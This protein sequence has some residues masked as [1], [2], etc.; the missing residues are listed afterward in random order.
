MIKIKN[1]TK[2]YETI[3]YNVIALSNLNFQF[4]KGEVIV[5]L[6]RSGSGKSTFLN[7]LGGFDNTYSGSY[8]FAKNEFKTMAQSE[9]DALRSKKIGFIFQHQVLFNNLTVIENVEISLDVLGVTNS[10]KKRLNAMKALTLVGLRRH[11]YKKPWQLSGGEKQRLAVARAI[12]KDPEVII[13]DEPTAALD[14]LTSKEVL[15]LLASVCKNKLLIIATHNKSIVK[16]YGTRI[17]ELKSGYVVRDELVKADK[18]NIEVDE[19]DKLLDEDIYRDEEIIESESDYEILSDK[20]EKSQI[21]KDL[22][23]DISQ[24]KERSE[25]IFHIDEKEKHATIQRRKEEVTTEEK[26]DS[27]SDGTED[28][29]NVKDFAGKAFLYHL[30]TY[31]FLASFLVIF[32][33]IFILGF[34]IASN[35]FMKKDNTDEI[36]S[37]IYK[38]NYVL[39]LASYDEI[40]LYLADKNDIAQLKQEFIE[41]NNID[42]YS[43]KN[44]DLILND[45]SFNFRYIN[46]IYHEISKYLDKEKINYALYYDPQNI[47]LGNKNENIIFPSLQTRYWVEKSNNHL[48]MN[49][50]SGQ[51]TNEGITP[52]FVEGYTDII[53]PFLISNSKL[54][55]KADEVLISVETLINSNVLKIK[56]KANI[57]EVY[58]QFEKLKDKYIEIAVPK[59]VIKED[60]IDNTQYETLRFK[61]VGI[62]NAGINIQANYHNLNDT[63]M[64]FAAA[65]RDSISIQIDNQTDNESHLIPLY[66]EIDQQ[67]YGDK[68]L[69]EK[70]LEIQATYLA[71]EYDVIEE[72]LATY[73][74]PLVNAFAEISKGETSLNTAVDSNLYPGLT[75]KDLSSQQMSSNNPNSLVY[76]RTIN[77]LF[78]NQYWNQVNNYYY[79]RSNPDE[80]VPYTSFKLNNSLV[81]SDYQKLDTVIK[82]LINNFS[83]SLDFSLDNVI[84]TLVI[85]VGRAYLN[86]NVIV[87]MITSIVSSILVVIIMYIFEWILAKLLLNIYQLFLVNRRSEFGS[88]RILGAK[89]DHIKQILKSEGKYL[90]NLS[91]LVV[92]VILIII[93]LITI[94]NQ[95]SLDIYLYQ[96]FNYMFF[97]IKI[98]DFFDISLF[99]VIS[100][101]ILMQAIFK[102]QLIDENINQNLKDLKMLNAITEWDGE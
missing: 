77:T 6:G 55:T 91:Y 79:Y 22:G 100:I 29:A 41:V 88:L 58:R 54:P 36:N 13:C 60:E 5:I 47:L 14:S 70:I 56:N 40:G 34:N 99:S 89:F 17:I 19:F 44:Y 65:A 11:A 51:S 30:K 53:K 3:N 76:E 31:L 73:Y 64:F 32:I 33:I 61:I 25:Q 46:D 59:M 63:K 86:P 96:P 71:N 78:V 23:L 2:V 9:I 57:N 101:F 97:N 81:N 42:T 28:M 18:S 15:D 8:Y 93:K 1:L 20:V 4:E 39:E 102:K 67:A 98:I 62:Y 75:Y 27:F 95:N 7:V 72:T 83:E 26:F 94:T 69:Q 68:N 66:M 80:N 38:N 16:N 37:S 10:R 12:V 50:F 24:Y 84:K 92:L 52:L 45:Y 35:V 49:N 87:S 90:V 82:Q 74:T 43:E 48:Y 85:T 21:L